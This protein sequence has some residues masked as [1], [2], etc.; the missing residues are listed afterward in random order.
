MF[1]NAA[2]LAV[3]LANLCAIAV[4]AGE[5]SPT[6]TITLTEQSMIRSDIRAT[7][8]AAVSVIQE[9]LKGD[10]IFHQ[11]GISDRRAGLGDSGGPGGSRSLKSR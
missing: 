10:V 3:L 8:P 6:I 7:A 2:G 5:Q 9:L 1:A 11:P 4:T